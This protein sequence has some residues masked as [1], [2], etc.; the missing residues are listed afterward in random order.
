MALLRGPGGRFVSAET[1]LNLQPRTPAEIKAAGIKE[2]KLEKWYDKERSRLQRQHRQLVKEGLTESSFPAALPTVRQLKKGAASA[3]EL[4]DDITHAISTA[5]SV[6]QSGTMDA[7]KVRAQRSAV[8]ESIT[9]E[10]GNID[11]DALIG[12]IF[13]KLDQMYGRNKKIRNARFGSER[14][15]ELADQL[16][17]KGISPGNL[18][19]SNKQME[20]FLNHLEDLQEAPSDLEIKPRKGQSRSAAWADYL[21]SGGIYE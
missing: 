9:D 10:E 21:T 4:L 16:I 14:V 3:A 8:M 19:R 11:R 18:L 6:E 7:K 2:E 17:E 13:K 1:W 20:I 5:Q 15:S 12:A